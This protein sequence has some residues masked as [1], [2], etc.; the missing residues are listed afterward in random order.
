MKKE[1][2][3]SE[4]LIEFA[5]RRKV[6]LLEKKACVLSQQYERAAQTRDKEKKLDAEAIQFLINESKYDL[7]DSKQMLKDIWM[8]FDLVEPGESTFENALKRLTTDNLQRIH[9]I[10]KIEEYKNGQLDLETIH[11]EIKKSFKAIKED[12]KER[13]V[14]LD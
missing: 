8:L 7:T 2:T 3:L 13:I 10:K 14:K 6:I 9:L 12:L 4:K 11:Q 5:D 1:L